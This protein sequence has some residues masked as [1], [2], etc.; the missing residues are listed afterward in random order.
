MFYLYNVILLYVLAGSNPCWG[1][2]K[3]GRISLG[4]SNELCRQYSEFNASKLVPQS[5]SKP[6]LGPSK[7]LDVELRWARC[8]PPGKCSPFRLHVNAGPPGGDY[9]RIVRHPVDEYTYQCLVDYVRFK[10]GGSDRKITKTEA[11]WCQQEAHPKWDKE[12]Y[13]Y[14][15][16]IRDFPKLIF[17]LLR[18]S[19]GVKTAVLL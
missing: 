17:V 11:R 14:N 8:D 3:V 13:S 4:L 5:S 6:A 7:N 15:F 16:G 9:E 19:A 1:L 10:M 2:V 18:C 12:D